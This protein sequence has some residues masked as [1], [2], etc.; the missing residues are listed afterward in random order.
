MTAPT[1][2]L[3]ADRRCAECGRPGA[4]STGICLACTVEVLEGKPMKSTAGQ[5]VQ[6]RWQ[7]WRAKIKKGG[8]PR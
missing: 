2:T 4:T 6:E 3:H 5:V 8:K 7:Q 1:I